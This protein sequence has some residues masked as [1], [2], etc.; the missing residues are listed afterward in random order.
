[1]RAISA[2]S[3]EAGTSTFWCRARIAL[4][5]R[6][7]M[8]ATGSVN[9]ILVSPQVARL[10]QLVYCRRTCGDVVCTRAIFAQA[11]RY[12]PGPLRN[13]RNL[14]SQRETTEAQTANAEL[15]EV[16]ARASADLASVV[17]AGRKLLFS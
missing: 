2:F 17:L 6:A 1:M 10:L 15:A 11:V 3:L 9:L 14:S 7:S 4:R 5:M 12:L 13:A 16:A 8:S